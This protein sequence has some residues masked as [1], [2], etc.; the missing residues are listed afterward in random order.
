[1]KSRIP[2]IDGLNLAV[3]FSQQIVDCCDRLVI[4]G[5][6]RRGRA[7]VGD[8]EIICRPRFS[9]AINTL[10]ERLE[11]M[12]RSWIITPRRKR[13]DHLMAWG[14]RYR[15]VTFQEF[16]VDIFIVLPD[17]QWGPDYV[18]RTGPADANM[19]LVTPVGK[20]A[21]E[22]RIPGVLLH[23]IAWRDGQLWRGNVLLDTP[24]E[25]DVFR[26][27][28]LP[29]VPP[30]MRS[31]IVYREQRERLK[32]LDVEYFDGWVG[33]YP[34]TSGEVWKPDKSPV[35]VSKL[36]LGIG[37]TEEFSRPIEQGRLF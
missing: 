16:P 13:N 27:C 18:L 7:E 2:W 29:W 23:G 12:R 17:R 20:Y 11:E 32:A 30:P 4:A 26:E 6:I 21:G 37:S 14:E 22:A 34:P 10:A 8:I 15:A 1:M 28:G 33:R 5:S 19:A 9:G 3:G 24:E 31:A 35:I 25:K 36:P